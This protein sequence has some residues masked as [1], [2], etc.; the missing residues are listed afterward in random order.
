MAEDVGDRIEG[1]Q[2]LNPVL[3]VSAHRSESPS[4]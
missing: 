4:L 3:G 2:G 1:R